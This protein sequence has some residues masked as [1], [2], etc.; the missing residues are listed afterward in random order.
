MQ[1]ESVSY[2]SQRAESMMG[3]FYLLTLYCVIRSAA[4][5]SVLWPAA[6]VLACALGMAS[7]E[8][9]VTAPVMVLLYDRTF[10][11]R[12]FARALRKR[13]V[14][15]VFLA[16]TWGVL[17][18]GMSTAGSRG[19]TIVGGNAVLGW[20]PYALS[21][22]G[23][24]LHYLRESFW[25]DSLCLYWYGRPA[26]HGLGDILPGARSLRRSWRRRSGACGAAG[27][28]DSWGHGSWASW[29]RRSSVVPI[30]SVIF[31]HRMYLSLA[32]VSA[33][34]VIGAFVL[35]ETLL[36]KTNWFSGVSAH[37]R[38][39]VPWAAF[40]AV[41]ACADVPDDPTEPG[42]QFAR[43]HVGGHGPQGALWQDFVDNHPRNARRF[44]HLG[45]DLA[46]NGKTALAV[47]LFRQS[48]AEPQRRRGPR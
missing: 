15:Y 11:S 26:A 46:D 8:V 34:V 7:K 47:G 13:W 21:Q 29:P 25:P 43:D 19:G 4:S 23:V 32:A 16:A 28:G 40:V 45:Q 24:I 17:A 39:D 10:L 48:L 14:L 27:S 42:L 5:K 1:T 2:I 6:A 38:W 37:R 18:Y 22:F 30:L 20:R 33:A 35:W 44:Y 3:L 12:T 9:M 31:E 41:D 36:R